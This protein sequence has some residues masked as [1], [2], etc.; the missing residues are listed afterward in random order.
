MTSS[1]IILQASEDR[2]ANSGV[3]LPPITSLGY[4]I[5]ALLSSSL[6]KLI[7]SGVIGLSTLS[8][9][10]AADYW[11][12]VGRDRTGFDTKYSP[13]G[14]NSVLGIDSA[15]KEVSLISSYGQTKEVKWRTFIPPGTKTFEG[16]LLTFSNAVE[17]IA[18]ARFGEPPISELYEV[19]SS[20]SDLFVRSKILSNL[21]SGTEVTYY[22]PLVTFSNGTQAGSGST[23]LSARPETDQPM[24]SKGGWVYFNVMQ[25][26][27]DY[28]KNLD[29][30]V[31]VD[32]TCYK[33]WFAKAKFD[34]SGNP[35][36]NVEHTCAGSGSNNNDGNNNASDLIAIALSSPTITQGGSTVT[37]NPAPNY[38]SLPTC[39]ASDSSGATSKLVQ[40]VG[41]TIS[42]LSGAQSVS[43]RQDVTIRCNGKTAVLGVLPRGLVGATLTAVTLSSPVIQKDSTSSVTLIPQPSSAMLPICN[44]LLPGF[45]VP[46]PYISINGNSITLTPN[47]RNITSPRDITIN[48]DG[49]TVVLRLDV[50]DGPTEIIEADG[51]LSISYKLAINSQDMSKAGQLF[52]AV[53]FPAFALLFNEVDTFYFTT[54]L[55]WVPLSADFNKLSFSQVTSFQTT[56]SLM[57]KTGLPMAR[58]RALGADLHVAYQA[59]NGELRYKGSIWK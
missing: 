30:R 47:A 54:P 5:K 52:V 17:T 51:S 41:S 35:A 28:I 59:A 21:V 23:R 1:Q 34:S 15:S 46:N 53:R 32:E 27:G 11:P 25:S 33:S 39:T 13:Y 6:L 55:G 16:S 10:F 57:I 22:S 50:S 26:P 38:V 29:I 19:S 37:I 18:A 36:E 7:A 58:L 31:V 14:G 20:S 44:S 9:A 12:L 4:R 45:G 24:T 49:K 56:Q 40:V 2:L 43:A 8:S 42:V 48:C 3:K